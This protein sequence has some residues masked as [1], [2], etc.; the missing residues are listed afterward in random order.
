MPLQVGILDSVNTINAGDKINILFKLPSANRD[1]V[2]AFLRDP[3]KITR[4]ITTPL[5]MENK[6]SRGKGTVH[7]FATKLFATPFP[8]VG[9][10][11][12]EI[13]F[14][15]LYSGGS[16]RA[17]ASSWKLLN[18]SGALL[19]QVHAPLIPYLKNSVSFPVEQ[20]G[21]AGNNSLQISIQGEVR[22]V[23]LPGPGAYNSISTSSHSGYTMKTKLP[24]QVELTGHLEYCVKG[25]LP[26]FL[27]AVPPSMRDCSFAMIQRQVREYVEHRF[28]VRLRKAFR[29]FAAEEELQ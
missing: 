22:M 1:Q 6:V 4:S 21:A 29:Q 8:D 5:T 20:E 13:R 15:V 19:H 28:P 17:R 14:A 10:V 11:V 12:P 23:P 9:L 25:I 18:Q 24:S 26:P 16:L 7:H 27:Q 2:A 3:A